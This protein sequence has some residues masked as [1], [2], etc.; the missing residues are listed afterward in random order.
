MEC[1]FKT[2]KRRFRISSEKQALQEVD[3]LLESIAGF[4]YWINKM[5]IIQQQVFNHEPTWEDL[6]PDCIFYQGKLI[7][8]F[9]YAGEHLI[10]CRPSPLVT[11]QWDKIISNQPQDIKL[12]NY[13]DYV[14]LL[15]ESPKH[16]NSEEILD[17]CS[18]L[19][20]FYRKRS[21]IQWA[22]RWNQFREYATFT[23]SICEGDEGEYLE[24]FE[25]F[26]KLVEAIY[27]IHLS[28]KYIPLANS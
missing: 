22:K 4:P 11:A 27:L 3:N 18:F 12:K 25:Y 15:V 23:Y 20:K 26:L 2:F 28:Q 24:D 19:N 13:P 6:F 9:I 21:A 16:L 8:K 7:L 14:K 5:K 1:N 10:N 17:P